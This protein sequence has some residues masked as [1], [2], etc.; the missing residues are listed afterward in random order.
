MALHLQPG[1]CE[2]WTGMPALPATWLSLP[3]LWVTP[4]S[5]PP[6]AIRNREISLLGNCEDYGPESAR[7]GWR[8]GPWHSQTNLQVPLL[9]PQFFETIVES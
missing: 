4:V 7:A 9:Q 6:Q 2:G 8:A 5:E 1:A 3:T